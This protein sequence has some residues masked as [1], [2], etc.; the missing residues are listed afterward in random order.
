[1]ETVARN[2]LFCQPAAFDNREVKA[3]GLKGEYLSGTDPS[4]A[5]QEKWET[6]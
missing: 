5:S 1:M 2:S 3:K 4:R 6:V